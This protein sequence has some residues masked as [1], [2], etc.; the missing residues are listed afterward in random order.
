MKNLAILFLLL[1]SVAF[2]QIT[3]EK[4]RT[5]VQPYYIASYS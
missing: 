1:P 3:R 5:A 2:A 4:A